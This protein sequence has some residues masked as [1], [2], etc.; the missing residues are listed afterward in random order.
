MTG[1]IMKR[2]RTETNNNKVEFNT[3]S[4]DDDD[5]DDGG[6]YVSDDEDGADSTGS[7]SGVGAV[8]LLTEVEKAN[9]LLGIKE[10]SSKKREETT[11]A[12][13]I[14]AAPITIQYE[15]ASMA[16]FEVRVKVWSVHGCDFKMLH[17]RCC[18]QN[19]ASSC[20]YFETMLSGDPDATEIDMPDEFT[21]HKLVVGV[22]EL[23]CSESSIR[24]FFDRL[25]HKNTTT[26]SDLAVA[27]MSFYLNCSSMLGYRIRRLVKHV[28]K[29]H[30]SHTSGQRW[31]LWA[32]YFH[33]PD[34]LEVSLSYC[35]A[36]SVCVNWSSETRRVA[37]DKDGPLMKALGP[38]T[39]LALYHAIIDLKTSL[40]CPVSGRQRPRLDNSY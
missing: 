25:H 8:Y 38:K 13:K 37:K 22:E 36:H 4:L 32:E 40:H 19:L 16:T 33:S 18:P 20:A 1:R 34:L 14:P 2:Q 5:D 12:D 3:T 35:A 28:K 31:L 27:Y 10:P 9:K 39:L 26:A 15:P 6:H 11:T 23:V 17:F 24:A 30:C 21:R 29:A 7:E